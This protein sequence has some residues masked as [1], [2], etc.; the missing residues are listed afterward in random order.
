MRLPLLALALLAA[1]ALA[2]AP[3]PAA[4]APDTVALPEVFD[5][6][7][8]GAEAEPAPA[9][10]AARTLS[11]S[12]AQ[13]TAGQPATVAADAG[14]DVLLVTYRPGSAGLA[15]TDTIRAGGRATVP[16]TFTQ[17][18]VARVAVPGGPSQNVSVRFD[19]TPA[20]GLAVLA[21][22]GLILFG[23]A[24]FAMAKLLGG[25]APARYRHDPP[26]VM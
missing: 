17:A 13:P 21:L 6:P 22:A 1:P 3:P 23:G 8:V 18:G 16:V 5:V 24:A 15:R 14:I 12:P 11:V 20:G 4:T 9:A 7:A 2:Q 25:G 19:R 26:D 10:S